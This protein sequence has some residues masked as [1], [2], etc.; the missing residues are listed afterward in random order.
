MKGI[1]ET[2][3]KSSFFFFFLGSNLQH[4]EV[5]RLGTESELY[6]PAY[7]TAIAAQPRIPNP[8]SEA[9]DQTHIL[10]DTSQIQ[11][12]FCCTTTGTSVLLIFSWS[13]TSRQERKGQRQH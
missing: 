10:M 9:R 8:M 13:F 5:P 6:L 1:E 11:I 12:C 3:I 4:M 2:G 7:T